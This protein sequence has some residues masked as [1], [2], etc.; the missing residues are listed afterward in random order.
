MCIKKNFCLILIASFLVQFSLPYFS[1]AQSEIPEDVV[2]GGKAIC[3]FKGNT[4]VKKITADG[5]RLLILQS[6]G[7]SKSSLTIQFLGGNQ[8]YDLDFNLFA[9]LGELSNVEDFLTGTK[10]IFKNDSST[11]DFEKTIKTSNSTIQL[12]NDLESGVQNSRGQIFVTSNNDQTIS[13]IIKLNFPKVSK[14][15]GNSLKSA[16][17]SIICRLKDIPVAIKELSF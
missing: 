3:T 2:V 15:E 17:L 9:S 8:N 14:I 16:S 5:N 13:G 1:F 12:T 6:G 7:I 11:V 10:L 4:I